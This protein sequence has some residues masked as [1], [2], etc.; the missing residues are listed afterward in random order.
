MKQTLYG[1]KQS[2]R[3][4]WKYMVEKLEAGGLK[5][6]NLDPCMFMGEKVIAVKYVGNILM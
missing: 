1:L 4:F 3:A 2:P 5:Q 6:S